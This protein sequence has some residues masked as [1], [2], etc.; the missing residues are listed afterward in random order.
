MWGWT[1]HGKAKED[2]LNVSRPFTEVQTFD[3]N[4][5]PPPLSPH[6]S[7]KLS[8]W[9]AIN[10]VWNTIEGER[11][12]RLSMAGGG[13][14]PSLIKVMTGVQQRQ[15]KKGEFTF[16]IDWYF[17]DRARLSSTTKIYGSRHPTYPP[18]SRNFLSLLRRR[19]LLETKSRGQEGLPTWRT[20]MRKWIMSPFISYCYKL[21]LSPFQSFIISKYPWAFS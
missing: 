13:V 11:K 8:S 3:R 15:N 16:R 2:L 18:K 1:L 5:P 17:W 21:H 6:A 10:T 4:P 12:W 7:C 20:L 9:V 19:W 14:I